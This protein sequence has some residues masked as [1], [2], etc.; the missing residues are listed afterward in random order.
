MRS[1]APEILAALERLA[2]PGEAE[3]TLAESILT[4]GSAD[5]LAR[6]FFHVDQ[7]R[8]RGLVR[9]TLLADGRPLATLL[10]L[11]HIIPSPAIG[12]PQNSTRRLGA[13]GQRRD[14]SQSTLADAR[15]SL[16][17]FAYLRQ[18]AGEMV[19]E[20][21]L[22]HSRLVLHDPRAACVIAAMA[23]PATLTD[24][25]ERISTLPPAATLKLIG[26]L[27][28]ASMIDTAPSAG[29][30]KNQDDRLKSWEFHDLLFHSRSR[31]GRS[32]AGF[33]AT[34]RFLHRPA[35]PALKAI[36]AGETY[37][38]YR[39]D[40]AQLERDDP[41][42]A[43]VQ[44][45]R[46]SLRQYGATP[47]T[48]KQ[49]GEFLYRVGRV[50]GTWTAEIPDA[51]PLATMEFAGR[52]FPAGGALYELEMYP[53][54]RSC[55]DLPGGMY[56][57]APAEHRLHRIAGP[58]AAVESLLDEAASSAGVDPRAVQVLICLASRFERIAWK[59]E[60]IA[61]ALT[62]KHVGVVY[63]TMYLAATAMGL[64]PCAVG[65]GDA[66]LFVRAAGT[67][68]HVESS[69]GEFLLGSRE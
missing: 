36:V 38:L 19:V 41:P 9:R 21:P 28:D 47:I 30:A 11:S 14:L 67:E 49:L 69:V 44:N 51:A 3:E 29:D 10:P 60:S 56:A 55:R 68:Y 39:P 31:R 53:I 12:K 63:Q 2:P 27:D 43:A 66:D 54:V 13:T 40:L 45:R 1:V 17:R 26:L 50:I 42:F 20:S 33:G 57:Y 6:W 7:F 24:V 59:Y 5:S 64:A 35:P 32:D 25:C 48:T 62:L 65:C 15:Y 61:Y 4:Q 34:Y 52:P 18:D 22:S 58:I 8:R 46:R 37:D 16:S 23:A